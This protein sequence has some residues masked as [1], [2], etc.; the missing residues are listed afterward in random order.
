MEPSWRCRGGERDPSVNV[1]PRLSVVIPS[2][3]RAESLRRALLA[4]GGQR[5][6]PG[7]FEVVVSLDGEDDPALPILEGF[8]APYAL[9]WL[10]RAHR[11]RAAA[12][13]AGAAVARGVILWF[14]DDDLAPAP[15]C[16]T[17]HLRAHAGDGRRAVVGPVP[18]PDGGSPLAAYRGLGFAARHRRMVRGDYR[19]RPVDVYAGNLSLPRSIFRA[20]GGFDES[21][22]VYGHEDFE[23]ARRLLED[24]VD[25]LY[26]PRAVAVQYYEKSAR[27]LARDTV[28]EGRTAVR[29]ARK[30]PDC[31]GD[32][33]L[34]GYARRGGRERHVMGCLLLLDRWSGLPSAAVVAALAVLER[35]AVAPKRFLDRAFDYLYWHGVNQELV[36]LGSREGLSKRLAALR[37]A[38]S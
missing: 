25:L 27:D 17:A 37:D 24:E 31:M 19:L 16:V 15:T 1:P 14:L 36:A 5:A 32:L 11:G 13:N 7:T 9:R 33:P 3:N 23:L 8:R 18:I 29:F 6:H 35:I 20:T 34:A 21:F 12:R 26:E 10:S 30:H 28:A 22:D 2:R 38:S 4:L